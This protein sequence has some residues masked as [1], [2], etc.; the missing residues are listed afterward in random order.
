MLILKTIICG[1]YLGENCHRDKPWSP[2]PPPTTTPHPPT[3]CLQQSYA[4]RD[5]WWSGFWRPPVI[6]TGRD[7]RQME[8]LV[9]LRGSG[10]PGLTGPAR[11]LPA[12]WCCT[13]VSILSSLLL[14]TNTLNSII[15][16]FIRLFWNTITSK[17][18]F[19]SEQWTT[20]WSFV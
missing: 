12:E 14:W 15:S 13:D 17:I 3:L 1:R 19:F 4:D 9:Q 8:Y 20:C 10:G 7:E 18:K 16:I 6:R 5:H 11:G 2:P